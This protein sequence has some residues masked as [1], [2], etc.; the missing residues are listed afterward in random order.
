[1]KVA[2]GF[3]PAHVTGIFEICDE[4]EEP[5]YQGSIGAGVSIKR[6]VRT[7]VTIDEASKKTLEIWINGHKTSSADVSE[8]VIEDF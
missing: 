6:G 5:I 4:S 3:A 8:M 1:M 2:Q 7:K